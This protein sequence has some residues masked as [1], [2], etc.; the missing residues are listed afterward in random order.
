MCIMAKFKS[1]HPVFFSHSPEV[2]L[3]P[4]QTTLMKL[5]AKRVSS[6][7][8]LI[9]FRKKSSLY[10]FQDHKYTS[11]YSKNNLAEYIKSS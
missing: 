9:I 3:G 5:Y 11:A 8:K 4:C 2:Y 6:Q 1:K 10:V 7:K